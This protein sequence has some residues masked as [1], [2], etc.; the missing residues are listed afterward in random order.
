MKKIK[1]FGDLQAFKGEWELNVKTPN[2][3]LRAIE[4]NRPGFLKA[5]DTGEYVVILVDEVNPDNTR[6]VTLDNNFAPWAD[7]VLFVLPRVSGETGIEVSVIASYAAMAAKFVATA[8]AAIGP[9]GQAIVMMGLSI[10]MSALANVI[11]G[12]K[13]SVGARDTESYE[14]KPSFVSNG[15]VNVV[16]A[17]HPYPIIAG[18]FLCGSIV[19]SSQIH[20]QDIPV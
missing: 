12:K 4:A 15:P 10:G 14:S 19:L 16:R 8:W 17:G 7:E 1:L 20:V 2:E 13:Q 5:A 18:R 6:Q 11:T 9:L 3:A